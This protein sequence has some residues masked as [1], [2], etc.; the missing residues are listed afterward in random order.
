M[1]LALEL[2][3]LAESALAP[4]QFIVDVTVSRHAPRKV[5]IIVDADQGITIDDCAEISRQ[6]SKNLDDAGLIEDNYSLEVSTPGVEHP[7]K[8]KRQYKKNVG[9]K[10]KVRLTDKIIEGKLEDVSEEK[11]TLTQEL[12]Q[13]KNKETKTV[14]VPFSDIEKAF[15]MVSF[16]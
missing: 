16:K 3:K 6:L 10:L 14:E 7:L 1:D 9:R 13:G 2:R 15:V 8:L 4:G 12:G 5:L 11:I